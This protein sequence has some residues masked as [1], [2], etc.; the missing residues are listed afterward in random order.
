MT[1][2]APPSLRRKAWHRETARD[3]MA[4]AKD[5]RMFKRSVDTAGSIARALERAYQQGYADG[6]LE[7]EVIEFD[8]AA[9]ELDA[10]GTAVEWDLIP[11]RPRD[12]FWRCCQFILGDK[13]EERDPDGHLV[14][15]WTI[16]NTPGWT[17]KTPRYGDGLKH[18]VIA[19][20]SIVPLAKLGLFE[21]I[22]DDNPRLVISDLGKAT[23]A[24]YQANRRAR[25]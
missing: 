24:L 17:I 20:R 15:S 2:K 21:Y 10:T 5:A 9:D 16:R 8:A 18:D 12:A 7:P 6:Q 1:N 25:S 11:P 13:P 22:Q 3:I 14:A 23:W 4:A 19:E